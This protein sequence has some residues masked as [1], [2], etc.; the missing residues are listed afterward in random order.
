MIK[1]VKIIL[2][3]AFF[4]G[5]IASCT[6]SKTARAPTPVKP[7]EGITA[8][9]PI[10]IDT[11]SIVITPPLEIDPS[12]F[13]DGDMSFGSQVESVEFET[14]DGDDGFAR[15]EPGSGPI[16]GGRATI[17]LQRGFLDDAVADLVRM[18]P[19]GDDGQGRRIFNVTDS[20]HRRLE[21]TMAGEVRRANGQRMTS[22]D[23]IELW[24]RF[25]K[26]RP[27]QGLALFRNVQGAENYIKGKDPL[28]NGFSAA[29]EHTIRIR[30]AKPD[31]FA[32]QRLASHKL[33]GGP[34]MLGVYYSGGIR[35]A[36]M[37][38]LPNPNS[39]LGTAFLK[40]CIVQ[41]GGDPDPLMSFSQGQY[42]AMTLYSLSDLQIARTELEGRATLHG[43]LSDRYFLSCKSED[44]HVRRFVRGVVDGGEILRNAVRAEGGPI[45]SVAQAETMDFPGVRTPV[46]QLPRPFRIIYRTDDPVSRIIAERTSVDLNNAGMPSETIPKNAETY[47][48]SLVNNDYDCAVGWVSETILTDPTE[49]LHL[50]SMW[51]DD[52]TDP[53]IRLREHR[54]IPLFSI[55]NYL[56]LRNDIRLHD[57]RITGIWADAEITIIDD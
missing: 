22:L 16:S 31:P 42:S 50:A 20:T 4:A 26:S 19:F 40:E 35:G 13:I 21:L 27:A 18:N 44:G 7:K 9:P 45:R 3:A 12:R 39:L 8:L 37:R 56:L 54:E 52:E 14:L 34:F 2:A 6:A 11:V 28:V 10:P 47:E 29:D 15:M 51:F 25:I 55:N 32:F 30:F 24:S 1:T 17:Y 5:F 57:D 48:A 23:F 43:L 33:V 49:Q 38:L 41:M 46:P 36:E 53:Q